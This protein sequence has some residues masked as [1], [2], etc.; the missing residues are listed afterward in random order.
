[1]T[2][3]PSALTYKWDR[4]RG[5]GQGIVETCWQVFAL[6][7]AIRYFEADES[8]KQLIPAGLGIGFLLA[9]LGLGLA[10]RLHL[11]ISSLIG[12]LWVGVALSIGGMII[13]PS[14]GSFVAFVIIAQ[15]LSSQSVP[16]LTHLYSANYAGHLRGSRLSTTFV[17]GSFAG[18]LAGLI[19][20]EV[21]DLDVALYPW[22]LG[23]GILA[24]LLSAAAA[25]RIPSL[26]ATSLRSRNPL[27][28]LSLIWK[29]GLFGWMLLA[30]MFMGIGN[31]MLIPIRVEYL[32]NPLYGVNA[33]NTQI[34][35]LLIST[36]LAFRLLSTKIW[37]FLF[38]RV[39]VVTLRVSLNMVFT[40]SI[41]CF[42]FTDRLW[43]IGV[44]CALLGLAFGGGGI[45]WSLY[46]TKIAPPGMIAS[47][48]SVHS[49]TTGLRM[50]AAPFIGYGIVS[51]A[52]PA[53]AAWLALLCIGISTLIFI[54][55]KPLIDA[56]GA[57]LD[58]PPDPPLD[59]SRPNPA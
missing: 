10:S 34:S 39:N 7:V 32:A 27:D 25:S 53:V 42:F 40:A 12:V 57:Q 49:F 6:L 31:L 26:P 48:M 19:G 30:W 29:D 55:L 47:Y 36:V 37:G 33:T 4:L 52:H 45:L 14:T 38:D 11:R 28:S 41:C 43:L 58:Q 50:A 1:M 8:V 56:K 24:A 22:L 23:G 46:V 20:G 2:P 16:L 59:A 15:I 51:L 3:D 9:P 35:G 54:P 44:G 5:A 18:I 21:L 17:I 13:S